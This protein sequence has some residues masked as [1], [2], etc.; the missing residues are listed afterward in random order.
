VGCL[1]T[2]LV[3]VVGMAA[4]IGGCTALMRGS[5]SRDGLDPSSDLV[6]PV[7]GEPGSWIV[8]TPLSS[9]V[10]R[11]DAGDED[12]AWRSGPM[13]DGGLGQQVAADERRVY[14]SDGRRVVALD[15]GDGR[16]L[17]SVTLDDEV[18][19]RDPECLACFDV[20]DDRLL[21]LTIDGEVHGLDVAGGTETWSHRFSDPSGRA[22]LVDGSLVIVDERADDL[23]GSELQVVDPSDGREL[24]RSVPTCA[25]PD[26]SVGPSYLTPADPLLPVD[27]RAAVLVVVGESPACRQRID[28][29]TGSTV[30]SVPDEGGD[31]FAASELV[32][33]DDAV[34]VR[35][36]GVDRI[37]LATGEQTSLLDAE[38]SETL[39]PSGTADGVL[40][41][42]STLNRG[43]PRSRL[44]GVDPVTGTR[45]WTHD[46][47]LSRPYDGPDPTVVGESSASWLW[48]EGSDGTIRVVTFSELG[49]GDEKQPTVTVRA[50]DPRSGEPGPEVERDLDVD[51]PYSFELQVL[52]RRE[53]ELVLT[54]EDRLRVLDTRTG[55][56]TAGWP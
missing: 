5:G 29:T 54:L 17:W 7:P 20:V 19:P 33:S 48:T 40:L 27:G 25:S 4:A 35:T 51:A 18:E 50:L 11:V 45:L 2:A 24:S 41:V 42:T 55:E 15:V 46:L 26:P 49:E 14:L 1:A 12:P 32:Q 8:E 39:V 47:G 28:L 56:I 37:D 44:V 10:M 34:F 36:G 53:D 43:S 22:L 9:G 31:I 13:E 52:E 3:I 23:P 21:V 6:V 38:D 16:R 30:W